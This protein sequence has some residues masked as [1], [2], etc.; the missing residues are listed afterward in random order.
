MWNSTNEEKY[1]VDNAR[2]S[3]QWATAYAILRLG[4][5]V[6]SCATQLKYLGNGD[7]ATQMGAIEALST[8]IGEQMNRAVAALQ[9]M[10]D[11]LGKMT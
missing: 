2:V 3:A 8:T 11:S 4:H 1:I 10:D 5:A 9:S 7:A 6:E